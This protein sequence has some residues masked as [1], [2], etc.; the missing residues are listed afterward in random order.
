VF[1]PKHYHTNIWVNFFQFRHPQF[2]QFSDSHTNFSSGY[3][4]ISKVKLSINLP[5]SI[6]IF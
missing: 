6:L 4:C 2:I 3:F 1:D 5:I